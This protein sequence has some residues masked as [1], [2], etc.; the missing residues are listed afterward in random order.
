M[1]FIIYIALLQ[2]LQTKF[3]FPTFFQLI[4]LCT[5]ANNLICF[6]EMNISQSNSNSAY[7]YGQSHTASYIKSKW[8]ALIDIAIWNKTS[9]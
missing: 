1:L 5:S 8:E 4:M 3:I 2:C 6:K 7:K 9:F